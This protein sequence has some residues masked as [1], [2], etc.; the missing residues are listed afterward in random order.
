MNPVFSQRSQ[1]IE[2]FKAM[3]LLKR[4]AELD[5]AGFDVVHM[6]AGEPDFPTAEPIR[7]AA[8]KLLEQ[9]GIK[10]TPA[11]GI[12]PLR[13]KIAQ[14]YR[15]SYGLNISP[16]RIIVT[17]G[18]SSGLLMLFALL[19]DA[20]QQFMIAD[21]GYPCN[22]QLLR[23]LNAEP[24][25][26]PTAAEQHYQLN[27]QLLEEHWEE[28][29]AG[30]LLASPANPTGAELDPETLAELAGKV[31]ARGGSLIVDEIYHGLSYETPS[32][33]VLQ[34]DDSAY[35]VNSFSKYFGMTGWRLGWIVAPEASVPSLEKLAQNLM[36]SP[37]TL[38]QYAALAAFDDET[39]AIL[40]TRKAAYQARRDRLVEGL[41]ALGFE[42][43]LLPAGAFYVYA[44][45]SHL[46]DD[47][48]QFCW[49][50]LEEE[51]IACTPGL[52]FGSYR[53]QSFIR[54]S[55]TTGLERI[56][57]ALE[58]LKRRFGQT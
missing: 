8:M 56:D 3:D 7:R 46:T 37:P 26:V 23:F 22:R 20:G 11:A 41:K 18:G 35:V 42:V 49:Q 27:A 33:S 50:L 5:A 54:F 28:S 32:Y 40:E 45:A 21:P 55:Y 57:L 14:W 10:Y 51:H 52:D 36:I 19:T 12:W 47:T 2:S 43:P 31:R 6:E 38:S 48:Y 29:T 16:E 1:R 58:R 17:T 34:C 24:Q 9:G 39:L 53:S 4:A 25:M 30:V 15:R 13:E 44:D